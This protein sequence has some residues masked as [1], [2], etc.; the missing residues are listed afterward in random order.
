MQRHV[1]ILGAGISGLAAAVRLATTAPEVRV[2]VLEAGPRPGG[3]L[4]TEHAE[5]FTLELGADS[6]I[7]NKPEGLEL[8]R[9]VGFEDELIQ[10]DDRFRR[11]FVVRDGKLLPVPVGFQVMAPTRLTSVLTSPVLSLG[12]KLRLLAERFVKARPD[13]QDESL[14]SFARRRLG[15]EVFDRLV[16][17]L[18]AGIYTADA[19]KL[20]LRA[21]LPRFLEM[22]QAHGSLIKATR[23]AASSSES[24]ARYSLFV[25]PR[26]GFSSLIEALV[27]RLP[28]GSLQLNTAAT[29]VT[30]G[31]SKRWTITLAKGQPLTADAVIV[32]LPGPVTGALLGGLDARFGELIRSIPY[33]GA[34]IVTLAYRRDQI[35]HPLDGFGVV[36]P[37]IE[38]RDLLA[39]SFSSVK[40]PCR[41]PEGQV[42]IRAFVGGARREDLVHRDDDELRLL[43]H[44]ELASLL[45]IRGRWHLCRISRYH[46]RMPQY[47]LGHLDRVAD[48][49][50]QAARWPG[51]ELAGNAFRGVGIPDCIRSGWQAADRAIAGLSGLV[52]QP[53][54]SPAEPG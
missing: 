49:E 32:A 38:R 10:T 24:G 54:T 37:D 17:P 13:N 51:L 43:A 3:I 16:Q 39:A 30:V 21:T 31:S 29:G 2:T 53:H 28:A 6:F 34:A 14:A 45:G 5:G 48:I 19:D 9:Q 46:G 41:A 36:V 52:P 40:F 50:A 44:E 8:C 22:E 23:S 12:G 15:H 27:A 33:A 7:T 26:G 18:A 47:H 20:S 25:T 35:T 42:L 11:T 1:V 4:Q